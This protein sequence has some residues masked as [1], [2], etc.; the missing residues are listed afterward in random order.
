MLATCIIITVL[1]FDCTVWRTVSEEIVVVTPPLSN[2]KSRSKNDDS[3]PRARVQVSYATGCITL[4]V[5]NVVKRR[6]ISPGRR[7]RLKCYYY[8][9]GPRKRL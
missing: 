1:E 9:G 8:R 4:F 5:I 3:P 2:A 7:A 6:V